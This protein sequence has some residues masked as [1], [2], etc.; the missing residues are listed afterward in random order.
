MVL[1]PK[2]AKIT[3]SRKRS[4]YKN[5]LTLVLLRRLGVAERNPTQ[6]CVDMKMLGFTTLR[7]AASGV[8]VPPNLLI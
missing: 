2:H 5:S 1:C 3:Y 6:I 8:Y 4:P 7:E